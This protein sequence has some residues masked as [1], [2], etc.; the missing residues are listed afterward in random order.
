MWSPFEMA[1]LCNQL[2]L[3]GISVLVLDHPFI[4]EAVLLGLWMVFLTTLLVESPAG[5]AVPHILLL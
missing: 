3:I 5:N 4:E 2:Y 1:S